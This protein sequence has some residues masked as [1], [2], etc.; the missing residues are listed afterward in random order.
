MLVEE[1]IV[2]V[3]KEFAKCCLNVYILLTQ[4]SKPGRVFQP[5]E[6]RKYSVSVLEPLLLLFFLS[7]S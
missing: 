7:L 1:N 4:Y 6:S 3:L 5:I 2:A